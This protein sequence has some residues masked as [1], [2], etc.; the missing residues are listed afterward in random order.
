MQIYYHFLVI[1][2]FLFRNSLLY[3]LY[4]TYLMFID[5]GTAQ[6]VKSIITAKS[7][8]NCVDYQ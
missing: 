7:P 1:G 6:G 8:G 2:I 4:K 3:I 5:E